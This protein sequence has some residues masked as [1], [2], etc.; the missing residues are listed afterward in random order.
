MRSAW[1]DQYF[2][3]ETADIESRIDFD[4]TAVGFGGIDAGPISM[5]SVNPLGSPGFNIPS[6]KISN[7]L[8]LGTPEYNSLEIVDG[9]NNPNR[10]S[11]SMPATAQALRVFFKSFFQNIT[12]TDLGSITYQNIEFRK[13]KCEV[14][15]YTDP[16]INNY[17]STLRALSNEAIQQDMNSWEAWGS[18]VNHFGFKGQQG[19]LITFEASLASMR[20]NRSN[21]IGI[22]SNSPRLKYKKSS[23]EAPIGASLYYENPQAYWIRG[24]TRK[25]F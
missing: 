17:L 6:K 3:Q 9:V 11:Y 2:L 14:E 4:T 8:S 10:I 7:P 16:T 22:I 23:G 20:F 24:I 19:G 5:L 18:V 12:I 15:S 1:Q 25:G 13:L 21:V